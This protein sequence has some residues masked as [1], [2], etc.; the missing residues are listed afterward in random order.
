M[1]Y[2]I[3]LI[4]LNENEIGIFASVPSVSLKAF[5]LLH[6]TNIE[7]MI[8]FV[9]KSKFC[10]ASFILI[11]QIKDITQ[12]RANFLSEEKLLITVIRLSLFKY[13]HSYNFFIM[14]W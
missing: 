3:S 2:N 11:L 13:A 6:L 7:D 1:L 12:R 14:M 8:V 4:F 5:C 10:N 9:S